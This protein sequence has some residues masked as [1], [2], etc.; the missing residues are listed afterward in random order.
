MGTSEGLGAVWESSTFSLDGEG[1][2]R[3]SKGDREGRQ[4]SKV[5]KKKTERGRRRQMVRSPNK[6]RKKAHAC[7]G[8]WED[9]NSA[10][11]L[12]GR[13]HLTVYL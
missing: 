10:Y 12:G 2:R 3:G 13:S 6:G 4:R 9:V 8:Y 5:G 11:V 7:G 1:K